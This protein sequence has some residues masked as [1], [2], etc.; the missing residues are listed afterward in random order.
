MSCSFWLVMDI[1]LCKDTG[2]DVPFTISC[3][4]TTVLF[5]FL[6]A[7]LAAMLVGMAMLFT[8]SVKRLTGT[9]LKNAR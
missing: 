3:R 4:A 1:V 9:A 2:R 8:L 5:S 7:V 6:L